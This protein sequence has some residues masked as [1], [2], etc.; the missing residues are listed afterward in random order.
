MRLRRAARFEAGRGGEGRAD[1][2][3]HVRFFELGFADG[4]EKFGQLAE[5]SA[6]TSARGM[7]SRLR[8][9]LTTSWI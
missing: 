9:A 4:G 8:D 6:M 5:A 3:H 7:V 2:L 1:F